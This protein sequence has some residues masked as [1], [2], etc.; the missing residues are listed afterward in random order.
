MAEVVVEQGGQA[1][2][3]GG[4]TFGGF[5][6][7]IKWFISY[8]WVWVL[9][10]VVCVGIAVVI[11]VIF[12][13]MKEERRKDQMYVFY[14]RTLEACELN[15]KRSWIKKEKRWWFLLLGIPT[16]IIFGL[17][18]LYLIL[19]EHWF[20][21]WTWVVMGFVV[22]LPFVFLMY[23]DK[24]MRVVNVDNHTVGYY[25]G[26]CLRMDGFFYIL[27][28]VGRKY[29]VMED[30]LCCKFPYHVLTTKTVKRKDK[31]GN[32]TTILSKDMI[33]IDKYV[34]NE[35]DNYIHVPMTDLVK[36]DSFFYMPTLVD[37]SR[38]PMDLRQK[39]AGAFH[40]ATGIQMAEQ[41]Y[42]QLG[43]VT[44]VA[45]DTNPHVV[46]KKKEPEKERDSQSNAGG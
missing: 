29:V 11:Y 33:E 8:W 13:F 37:E 21:F 1:A 19:G 12:Y 28:K 3:S 38:L 27:L 17:S 4:G 31:D 46:M 9:I 45:V 32:V 43:R 7:T 20:F 22:W 15:K 25:R 5:S 14:E 18:Y 40:F 6:E 16:G 41:S 42:S 39:I 30:I 26:H 24:S 10:I 2:S 36:E 23:K 34:W 35:R 44:N